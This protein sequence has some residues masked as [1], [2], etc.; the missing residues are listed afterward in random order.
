MFPHF[1]ARI[2]YGQT[3]RDMA[4]KFIMEHGI[5]AGA[6]AKAWEVEMADGEDVA[7]RV[8]RGAVRLR[9]LREIGDGRRVSGVQS[10]PAGVG[11]FD[12][13]LGRRG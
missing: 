10:A 1:H 7:T 4:S 5:L 6:A 8:F 2:A 9:V 13:H 11:W 3:I 12:V